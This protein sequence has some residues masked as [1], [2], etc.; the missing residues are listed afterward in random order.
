MFL[1]SGK[2]SQL[3]LLQQAIA[4]TLSSNVA[5]AF[6]VALIFCEEDD[7][8]FLF[9][10]VDIA[11][12]MNKRPSDCRFRLGLRFAHLHPSS[13]LALAT[14]ASLSQSRSDFIPRYSIFHIEVLWQSI[15]PVVC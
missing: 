1:S 12:D 2:E 11:K 5:I 7:S 9:Q 10:S 14:I 8:D 6:E 3:R 13:G 15:F 4:A